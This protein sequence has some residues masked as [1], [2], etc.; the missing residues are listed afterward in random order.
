MPKR[1][2]C[3]FLLGAVVGLPLIAKG[4]LL[5]RQVLPNRLRP[6]SRA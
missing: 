6:Q 4:R 1:I 3:V 5:F 2:V